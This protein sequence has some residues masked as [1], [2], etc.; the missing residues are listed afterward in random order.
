MLVFVPPRRLSREERIW[1]DAQPRRMNAQGRERSTATPTACAEGKL[2]GMTSSAPGK[3]LPERV[4]GAGRGRGLASRPS[5]VP[6]QL[7][8]A[9]LLGAGY[10]A[11][12]HQPVARRRR[13]T[14][15]AT[16]VGRCGTRSASSLASRGIGLANLVRHGGRRGNAT[17]EVAG[18]SDG[19]LRRARGSRP[20]P[21]PRPRASGPSRCRS[22]LRPGRKRAPRP[23]RAAAVTFRPR[24]RAAALAAESLTAFV[25][26]MRRRR[27]SPSPRSRS[28][29][30]RGSA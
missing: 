10:R 27:C 9:A 5:A 6:D 12:R 3:L 22:R 15:S 18:D 7:L 1:D 25:H 17:R 8:V 16:S 13:P 21:G 28:R 20:R 19:R 29:R 26:E 4:A 24:L 30:R 11:L 23:V 14:A 2:E